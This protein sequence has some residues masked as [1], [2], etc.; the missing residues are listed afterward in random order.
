[1]DVG[2]LL[3]QVSIW[4]FYTWRPNNLEPGEFCTGLLPGPGGLMVESK[5][6]FPLDMHFK[7]DT[8]ICMS[9]PHLSPFQVSAVQDQ[10]TRFTSGC[11]LKFFSHTGIPCLTVK[12]S[13]SG[14]ASFLPFFFLSWLC[15]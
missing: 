6:S 8:F 7:M 1:M 9:L 14:I 11:E 5:V 10:A 15:I 4:F 2:K 12:S 13:E 3:G